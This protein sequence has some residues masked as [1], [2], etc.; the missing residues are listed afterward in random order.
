MSFHDSWIA[1]QGMTSGEL[2][3][4]LELE[5]TGEVGLAIEVARPYAYGLLSGGW[6]ILYANFNGLA[7]IESMRDLGRGHMI[8]ACDIQDQVDE[9]TA[10]IV[11][12]RN[13]E[14]L[15]EISSV[16]EE[17]I[18]NGT[19]PA[20]F[21]AIRG[22]YAAKQASDPQHLWICEVPIDLGK[23][24]CG[25]RHDEDKSP[26]KGLRPRSNSTWHRRF[27]QIARSTGRGASERWI[28]LTI[29]NVLF[30]GI[31][32]LGVVVLLTRIVLYLFGY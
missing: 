1:V 14:K 4:R 22:H 16:D 13:G 30:F 17:I 19:P 8:L 5:E 3:E 12:V 28:V 32:I 10:K 6:T 15:W 18:I 23:K 21:E 2:L 26:F 7:D 31:P 9:I 27:E 25:F 20:E 11:G 29:I 24:L